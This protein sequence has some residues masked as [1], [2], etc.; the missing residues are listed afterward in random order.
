[1]DKEKY[2]ELKDHFNQEKVNNTELIKT[3]AYLQHRKTPSPCN[4]VAPGGTPSPTPITTERA[5]PVN[6]GNTN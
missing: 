3:L 4:N 2:K 6:Y 5:V 1:M